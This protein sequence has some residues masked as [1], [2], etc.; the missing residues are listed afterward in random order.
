M[1]QRLIWTQILSI[2]FP[3]HQFRGSENLVFLEQILLRYSVLLQ[4]TRL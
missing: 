2:L 1:I 4:Y 3:N